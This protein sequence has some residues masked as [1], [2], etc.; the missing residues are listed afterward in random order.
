MRVL[1]VFYD[2]VRDQYAVAAQGTDFLTSLGCG[3]GAVHAAS[4]HRQ[5]MST[6]RLGISAEAVPM[7][8][9]SRGRRVARV[10]EV[11]LSVH[12]LLRSWRQVTDGVQA[13]D[14]RVLLLRVLLTLSVL[15]PAAFLVEVL[16]Y[17]RR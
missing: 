4:A 12:H 3:V 11:P 14:A 7:R 10:L 16:D 15:A 5:C 8:R 1:H 17:A 9:R 6:A 2:C 13:L